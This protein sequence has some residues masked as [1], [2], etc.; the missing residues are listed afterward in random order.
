M[1]RASSGCHRSV[2][3]GRDLQVKVNL[4]VFKDEKS[5]DAV[6]FWSWWW[7]VAIFH[8]C[9]W[10]DQHLLPHVF[11]SLQGFPGNL[12]R[13]LGKDA[14]LNE[15]MQMLDKHYCVIMTFDALSKELYSFRQGSSKNKAEFR[16]HLLQQVQILQSEYPQRIQPE[17][18]EEM[19]CGCFYEGIN[20]K[21]QQMLAHKVDGEQPVS[22]SDLLQAIWKLERWVGRPGTLYHQRWLWLVDQ[23]WYFLRCQG[24]YFPCV[25][26]KATPLLLLE[27]WPSE[28][29]RLKMIQVWSWK[30]K[31]RQNLKLMRM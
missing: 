4:P 12:A 26:W 24:I 8:W 16:V 27:L 15:I 22:Y 13:S 7:D 17:H 6:T 18:M 25:S 28:M 5:K 2:C 29:M 20:S 1:T 14:T 30:V 11:Y 19:K 31:E 9:G 3:A 10:D 21:Y 23:T